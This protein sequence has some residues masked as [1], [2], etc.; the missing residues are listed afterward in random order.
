MDHIKVDE[1]VFYMLKQLDEFF[2]CQRKT[3]KLAPKRL[4]I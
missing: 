3:K 2:A 4:S 1:V